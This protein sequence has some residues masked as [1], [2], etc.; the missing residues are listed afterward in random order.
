LAV[1]LAAWSALIHFPFFASAEEVACLDFNYR[2][3]IGRPDGA[4]AQWR[5]KTE[6]NCC[7]LEIHNACFLIGRQGFA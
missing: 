5:K 6:Y 1:D 2:V 7:R 4:S 3:Q